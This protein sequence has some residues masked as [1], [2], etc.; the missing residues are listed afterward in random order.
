[1]VAT[2]A[3]AIALIYF[4]R[5][6][7]AAGL[8]DDDAWYVLLARSLATGGG[9]RLPDGGLPKYPPGF[10][11]LLA[12]F[13]LAGTAFPSNV[14][15]L[16][17]VSVAAMFGVGVA[18][19]RY[20]ERRSI[21]RPFALGAAAAIV[22]TPALVFLA[23]STLMSECVF[24]LA[25][26][27]SVILVERAV[28][29]GTR[30][31]VAAAG[32]MAAVTLLLRTAGAPLL[33]AAP[34]YFALKRQ[35]SF[36]ALFLVVSL[37]CLAPWIAYSSSL[38][39]SDTTSSYTTEL[40]RRWADD[41]SSGRASARE[42]PERL[43]RNTLD[44]F[45]RD[46]GALVLPELFRGPSESGEETISVGGA[47]SLMASGSMGSARGTM[48]VS[49][50]LS[51]VALVGFL[52]A[53][54]RGCTVA[55][56][57][58]PLSLG[59]I[60]IW[61]F[62]SFRFVVPLTPFLFFYLLNGVRALSPARWGSIARVGLACVV[63]MHIADHAIYIARPQASVWMQNYDEVDG[64]LTWMQQH[65]DGPG[66]VAA[67]NPALVT[68]RTGRTAVPSGEMV[69]NWDAWKARGVRYIVAFR[70]GVE[71]PGTRPYTLL[72]RT[73]RRGLFVAQ[74]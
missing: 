44:I 5:L 37:A 58:V 16:K 2:V 33:I 3:G 63:L 57:L 13:F 65:L 71:L 27:V 72:Y 49:F 4:L 74:N 54:R 64:L 12:P 56:F 35:W 24:T 66:D 31:S 41:P 39:H 26:L 21:P 10:P 52:A 23:T 68:L 69:K 43:W 61:P 1:L 36:A 38:P 62:W 18:S 30:T 29:A 59:L 34:L 47:W 19:V 53:F 28:R 48:V 25:L 22:L 51:A 60:V 17:L 8:I 32:V 67:T 20:L 14:I 45:G 40:G 6:N 50:V 11:L 46:V 73:N 42:I 55:E 7:P 15:A 70:G 9:Y